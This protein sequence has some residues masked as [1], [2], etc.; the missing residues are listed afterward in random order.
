VSLIQLE[1]FKLFVPQYPLAYKAG[2]S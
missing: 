2:L 1:N